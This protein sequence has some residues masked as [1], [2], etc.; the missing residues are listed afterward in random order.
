MM[1]CLD[2]Y[3][4]VHQA[5]NTLK[6]TTW[7]APASNK[8][9]QDTLHFVRDSRELFM[10]FAGACVSGGVCVCVSGCVSLPRSVLSLCH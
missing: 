7:R 3:G 6:A 10:A 9:I 2:L 5:L 1:G 4:F 8:E